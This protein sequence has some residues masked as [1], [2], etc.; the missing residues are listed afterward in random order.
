V[1]TNRF[2]FTLADLRPVPARVAVCTRH[3]TADGGQRL[4]QVEV[5]R[6]PAPRQAH[7]R[8]SLPFLAEDDAAVRQVSEE[9][10]A[11]LGP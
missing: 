8:V 1:L 4:V 9:Q 11:A 5:Y 2:P 3:T 10:R 7:V 6:R